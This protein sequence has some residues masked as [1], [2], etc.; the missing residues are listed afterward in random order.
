MPKRLF[1]EERD[2]ERWTY[3]GNELGLQVIAAVRPIICAY[4]DLGFSARDIEYIAT[5][6]VGTTCLE[7]MY[8]HQRKSSKA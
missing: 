5:S 1:D 6:V 7:M 4:L 3:E 2:D 8:L